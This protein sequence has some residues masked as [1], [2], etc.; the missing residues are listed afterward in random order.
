MFLY[1][2]LCG[3]GVSFMFLVRTMCGGR[4]S[5]FVNFEN[6]AQFPKTLKF[7]YVKITA[8]KV[9]C[10]VIGLY[11]SKQNLLR[12][13]N[14]GKSCIVYCEN[15]TLANIFTQDLQIAG[16]HLAQFPRTLSQKI[17][18]AKITAY[19]QYIITP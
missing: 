15:K 4:G 2:T 8:Y 16:V 5:K 18:Y 11:F 6:L 13:V 12:F 10:N 17:K 9:Y 1:R 3:P 19:I 14:F 7:K